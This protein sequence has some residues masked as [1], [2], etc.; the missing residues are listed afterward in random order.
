MAMKKN[1]KV[2]KSKPVIFKAED[3]EDFSLNLPAWLYS[4]FENFCQCIHIEKED[5]DGNPVSAPFHPD[6]WFDEQ[7]DF[8]KNRTGRD[9]VLKAR[10]I[11]MTTIN[12]ILDLYFVLSKPGAKCA[13]VL[14]GEDQAK[15]AWS[16]L[17]SALQS[18]YTLQEN[19]RATGYPEI[20]IV[21]PMER[22]NQGEM[23]WTNGS[24]IRIMAAKA[25]EN[26]ADKQA[27]SFRFQRAHLSE[28]AYWT[29]PKKTLAG[30]LN[31]INSEGG[32]IVIESTPKLSGDV[33]STYYRKAKSGENGF[34]VHFWPWYFHTRNRMKNY[35]LSTTPKSNVELDMMNPEGTHKI[36]IEQLAFWQQKVA[37]NGLD[38][39]MIDFPID[40]A[41]CWLAKGARFLN[42][43]KLNEKIVNEKREPDRIQKFGKLDVR[44]FREPLPYTPYII[45]AD[46]AWGTGADGCSAVIIN[47][48]SNEVVATSRD[49]K[50]RPEEFG[51]ALI[52]LGRFFNNALIAPERNGVG[53]AVI[54]AINDAYYENLYQHIKDDGTRMDSDGWDTNVETRPTMLATLELL[55]S[56]D[57]VRIPC[58]ELY[59]QL[60]SLVRVKGNKKVQAEGK[61]TEGGKSDDMAFALMIA[62]E[63]RIRAAHRWSVDN[64]IRN[65][66]KDLSKVSAGRNIHKGVGF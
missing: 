27:R 51:A 6:T 7:R 11:G 24:T 19:L 5:K 16:T 12:L 3:A 46:V 17:N 63:V 15:G 44:M 58:E 22:N 43:Q 30:I 65:L 20:E 35:P 1:Q 2:N 13:V 4:S 47:A 54:R 36:D 66:N 40:E 29:H 14:Q 42:P 25:E 45:G 52:E 64:T 38:Q 57:R 60:S 8:I 61:G 34:K 49:N 32:E 31:A 21:P 55:I 62:L 18:L 28:L 33:F 50:I 23:K 59:N 53:L 26:A 41:S 39:T 9:L 56:E 10:Q 48:L 37:Q